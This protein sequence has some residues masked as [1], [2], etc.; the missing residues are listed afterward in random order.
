MQ[1]LSLEIFENLPISLHRS[2]ASPNNSNFQIQSSIQCQS[3]EISL[4]K[5]SQISSSTRPFFRSQVQV[6]VLKEEKRNLL[7]QVDELSKASQWNESGLHRYRSQSF[8]EQR[9]SQRNLRN[10]GT[11]TRD[12]GTMCGAMTRDVG[13]SHQQ[14]R[15]RLPFH[16]DLSPRRSPLFCYNKA[17]KP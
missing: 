17:E 5:K 8:S 7:R 15:R 16:A 6:S 14:V 12:M 4:K 10:A 2:S 9:G 11:P 3:L 13:V 1:T